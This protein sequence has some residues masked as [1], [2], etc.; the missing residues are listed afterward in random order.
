MSLPVVVWDTLLTSLM[1]WVYT[2]F[3][4]NQ[5]H[6]KILQ[7]KQGLYKQMYVIYRAYIYSGNTYTMK[8]MICNNSA[9]VWHK[10]TYWST[11]K[12]MYIYKSTFPYQI[13]VHVRYSCDF[14]CFLIILADWRC[15]YSKTVELLTTPRHLCESYYDN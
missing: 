9:Y 15:S 2:D 4:F 12:Y 1:K 7:Y 13:H 14:I 10:C 5:L 6:F 11:V 8:N 3:W